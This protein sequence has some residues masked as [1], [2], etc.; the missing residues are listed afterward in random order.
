MQALP[1]KGSLGQQRTLGQHDTTRQMRSKNKDVATKILRV[2]QR[3]E[4]ILELVVKNLHGS[5]LE[6]HRRF[7]YIDETLL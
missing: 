1:N 4:K 6:I 7:I 5:F 2:S 3:N